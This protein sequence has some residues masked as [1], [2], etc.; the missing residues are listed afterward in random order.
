VPAAASVNLITHT[1]THTNEYI[2][3]TINQKANERMVVR[4]EKSKILSS[5]MKSYQTTYRH[6]LDFCP[7]NTEVTTETGSDGGGGGWYKVAIA[8]K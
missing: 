5:E 1:H 7:M 4:V 6:A 3:I 8:R 2:I